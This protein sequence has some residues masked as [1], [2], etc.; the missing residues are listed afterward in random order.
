MHGTA[1]SDGS[2]RQ[3]IKELVEDWGKVYPGSSQ[4]LDVSD[5]VRANLV[6]VVAA[7]GLIA[8]CYLSGEID[9][10]TEGHEQ[11]VAT[12]LG[13]MIKLIISVGITTDEWDAAMQEILG[14]PNQR[15]DEAF[16]A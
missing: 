14:Q 1:A 16:Q 13:S 7:F 4:I 15:N 6:I 8:H 5:L 9:F 10:R 11:E 2:A 3:T 12:T